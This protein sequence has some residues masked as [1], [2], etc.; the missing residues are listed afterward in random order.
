MT[1]EINAAIEVLKAGG[2]ILYPTD[3]VWGIGCDATNEEAVA[4]VFAIKKREDCKSLITLVCD[5]DML[6]KYVRKIPEIALN[7]LEVNDKPM[8][9]IYPEATGLAS[10]VIAGDG[11]VGIRIPDNEFCRKLIYKFRK[12]IVSTSANISGAQTPCFYEDIPI[13]IIDAVDWVA[14]PCL[15]EG[16]TG[17]ASQIIKVGLTGEIE[18]IR[19]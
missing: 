15:Q 12:P 14:D 2:I 17:K 1:E 16:S 18:I 4:K 10:N 3:T 5:E 9:I 13:E 8:T 11:S 19:K 7:L 6:C